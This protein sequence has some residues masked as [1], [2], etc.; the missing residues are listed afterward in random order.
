ME[1]HVDSFSAVNAAA[2]LPSQEI[3]GTPNADPELSEVSS[4]KVTHK[5]SENEI[6]SASKR[7][8]LCDQEKAGDYPPLMQEDQIP[9]TRSRHSS[10]TVHSEFQPSIPVL[11]MNEDDS[12]RFPD[13]ASCIG[14]PM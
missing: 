3:S 1:Q 4:S 12:N 9:G 5:M 6:E 14:I 10:P 8:K 7:Q 13:A 2:Q 11:Q